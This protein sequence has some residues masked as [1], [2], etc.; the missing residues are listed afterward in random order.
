MLEERAEGQR[1]GAQFY[2]RNKQLTIWLCLKEWDGKTWKDSFSL[3]I[4]CHAAPCGIAAEW[5]C[6]PFWRLWSYFGHRNNEKPLLWTGSVVDLW[7]WLHLYLS[8]SIT[9]PFG[10]CCFSREERIH[11]WGLQKL[12]G[13]LKSPPY[14][15]CISKDGGHNDCQL[16]FPTRPIRSQR[17]IDVSKT[18]T[19]ESAVLWR[20]LKHFTPLDYNASYLC[21]WR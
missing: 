5:T 17:K 20:V 15:N 11:F 6:R 7:H 2:S 3:N 8:H 10:H 18:D 9:I 12:V 16:G 14:S 4:K 19:E 1:N 13:T 21:L